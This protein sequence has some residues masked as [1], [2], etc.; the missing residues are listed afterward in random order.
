VFCDD[1]V[2]ESAFGR[3]MVLVGRFTGIEFRLVSTV[4]GTI[5][6]PLGGLS[7]PVLRPAG[8]CA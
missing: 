7:L 1:R 8:L 4:N 2:S 5:L 3:L 6:M